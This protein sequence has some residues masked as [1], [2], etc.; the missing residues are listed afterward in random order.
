LQSVPIR[1]LPSNGAGAPILNILTSPAHFGKALPRRALVRGEKGQVVL[2]IYQKEGDRLEVVL[3]HTGK[4]RPSAFKADRSRYRL[5]FRKV[6][7]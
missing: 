5:I 4:A 2:G 3:N 7:R 1:S 6:S